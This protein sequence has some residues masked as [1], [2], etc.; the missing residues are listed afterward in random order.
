MGSGF[1][2][3][4]YIKICA[5]CN[6]CLCL[7]KQN[8]KSSFRETEIDKAKFDGTFDNFCGNNKVKFLI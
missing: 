8:Q 1:M 5:S 4:K 3:G 6:E 2:V 7:Y